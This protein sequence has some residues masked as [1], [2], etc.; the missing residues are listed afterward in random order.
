MGA[1]LTLV[2][3]HNGNPASISS[4]TETADVLPPSRMSLPP[5]YIRDLIATDAVICK[6][7]A[8]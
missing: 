2:L 8:S 4:D 5:F 1:T 7:I 6:V 3:I